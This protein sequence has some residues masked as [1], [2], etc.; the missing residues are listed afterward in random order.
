METTWE[1]FTDNYDEEKPRF[2][3]DNEIKTIIDMIFKEN[4]I[5]GN[6][7]DALKV[8]YDE[9][10]SSIKR[11]IE[12]REWCPK[13]IPNIAEEIRKYHF[14]SL[15]PK[16]LSVGVSAAETLGAKSTQ[17]TLNTFHTSGT[18]KTTLNTNM[19]MRSYIKLT[20]ASMEKFEYSTVIFRNKFLTYEDVL[21]MRI[22]IVGISIKNLI[23]DTR[24]IPISEFKEDWWHIYD[25]EFD[26]LSIDEKCSCF[27]RLYLNPIELYKYRITLSTISKRLGSNEDILKI[28]CS[29]S[30]YGIIDI[31]V[32]KTKIQ[33]YMYLVTKEN[34]RYEEQF[35][36]MIFFERILKNSFANIYISGKPD[37][38]ELIPVRINTKEV[39]KG[40]RPI[41]ER[42]F[43]RIPLLNDFLSSSKKINGIW[44][45]T[46]NLDIIDTLGITQKHFMDLCEECGIEILLTDH[47]DDYKTTWCIVRTPDALPVFDVIENNISRERNIQNEKA[48]QESLNSKTKMLVMPPTKLLALSEYVYA[49]SKGHNLTTL[50]S[51]P[52]IDQRRTNSNNVFTVG[53]YFGIEASRKSYIENFKDVLGDVCS[54]IHIAVIAEL[55][56]SRGIPRGTSVGNVQKSAGGF[57]IASVAKAVEKIRG[58]SLYKNSEDARNVTASIMIGNRFRVGTGSFDIGQ[59]ILDSND[60]EISLINDDI[61]NSHLKDKRTKSIFRQ[62]SYT[63]DSIKED[64]LLVNLD[65]FDNEIQLLSIPGF[66][67]E[68]DED[69]EGDCGEN[70]DFEEENDY[71][72]DEGDNT[73]VKTKENEFDEGSNTI[74]NNIYT[75]G[76]KVMNNLDQSFD[77]SNQQINFPDLVNIYNNIKYSEILPELDENIEEETFE[78]IIRNKA[79]N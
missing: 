25:F 47:E 57:S 37:I 12:C 22:G 17:A 39:V 74:I 11:D 29:P 21:N 14:N 61:F 28:F 51:I 62:R 76:I 8:T 19:I 18:A 72:N 68:I 65:D 5:V 32:E 67:Q 13:D 55:F 41:N 20:A 38:T 59:D 48:A 70:K 60:K 42:D 34:V 31:F 10:I 71:L 49:I 52:E 50:L 66:D 2:L 33:E 35:I 7:K 36:E 40:I 43:S 58:S 73:D 77:V 44:F 6:G 15:I 79:N 24:I 54:S 26:D 30:E 45:C 1:V 4:E 27:L 69:E 75:N 46:F 9:I 53:Q 64:N 78:N 16:G 63:S 3:T 56:N 23:K